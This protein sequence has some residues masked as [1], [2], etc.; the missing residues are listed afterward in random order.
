KCQCHWILANRREDD[1]ESLRLLDPTRKPK[2]KKYGHAVFRLSTQRHF[3]NVGEKGFNSIQIDFRLTLSIRMTDECS[4]RQSPLTRLWE[5][6]SS[7][8]RDCSSFTS[9]KKVSAVK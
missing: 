9:S 5:S 4:R 6:H 7:T 3:L 8:F 2:Q 1:S